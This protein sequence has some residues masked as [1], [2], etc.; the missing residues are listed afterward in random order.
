MLKKSK[1][2]EILEKLDVVGARGDH[3][4]G[5]TYMEFQ[6]LLEAME[7]EVTDG[8]WNQV[9]EKNAALFHAVEQYGLL[10]HSDA[11]WRERDLPDSRLDLL[12]AITEMRA[13]IE[14]GIETEDG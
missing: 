4:I 6:A 1:Q 14:Y 3:N 10:V 2:K 7:S 11:P 12:D 8:E 9:A 13:T 5:A